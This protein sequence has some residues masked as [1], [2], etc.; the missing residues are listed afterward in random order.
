MAVV[1]QADLL[2]VVAPILILAEAAVVMAL[3]VAEGEEVLPV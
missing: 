2:D 1:P 3:A